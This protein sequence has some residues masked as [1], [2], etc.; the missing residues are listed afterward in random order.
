MSTHPPFL[1]PYPRD[2]GRALCFGQITLHLLLPLLPWYSDV[3]ERLRDP[4]YACHLWNFQQ[5]PS[6]SL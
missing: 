4:A 3:F 6:P 2:F 5:A 1:P